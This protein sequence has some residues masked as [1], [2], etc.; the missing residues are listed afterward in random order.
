MVP[1]MPD[2]ERR[3]R[4]RELADLSREFQR[5]QREFREDLDVRRNEAMAVVLE[6]ANKALRQIAETEKYDLIVQDAVV[7]QSA[8]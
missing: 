7:L 6:R 5:K 1:T 8:D 4:E 2:A 3:N